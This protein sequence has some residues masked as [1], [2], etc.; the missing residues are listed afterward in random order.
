MAT[1]KIMPRVPRSHLSVRV[2]WHDAGWDGTVCR[3]PRQN[4]SC[5]ALNRIGAAKRDETEER[6]AGQFLDSVPHDEAPPCFSERVSFLSARPQHRLARHAYARTS[7]DHR[8]IRD[9]LFLHPAFS[10]AATPF[11]LLL[12]GRVG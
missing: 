5:L 3:A 2:P 4:S 6:P 7:D 10:A 8:H 9:T 11:G 12:K 1:P